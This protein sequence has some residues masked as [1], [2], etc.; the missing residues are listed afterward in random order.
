MQ[1]VK[2]N[3]DVYEMY[4][5]ESGIFKE[6]FIEKYKINEN[7]TIGYTGRRKYKKFWIK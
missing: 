5:H 1:N 4:G 6:R 3:N 7:R 2:E